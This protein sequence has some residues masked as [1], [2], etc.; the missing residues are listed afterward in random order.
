MGTV[1]RE[2]RTQL[3]GPAII[4]RQKCLTDYPEFPLDHGWKDRVLEVVLD[5]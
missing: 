3:S 1:L 5:K 2:D 4:R